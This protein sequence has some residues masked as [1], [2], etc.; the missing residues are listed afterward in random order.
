[1]KVRL[2]VA[3]FAALLPALP[4]SG[5][6]HATLPEGFA[7]VDEVVP[8][9]VVDLRYVTRK[10]FVGEPI[11]GYERPRCI[12]TRPAAEALAKVQ[13]DLKPFGLGL[14][15][16]DAYRP[17]QAVDHFA[18]WARKLDDKRMK[19]EYYPEVPKSELFKRGYI[20]AKSGHSR[21]STVDLT[22]VVL[23]S[24]DSKSKPR[25]IDMGSPFDFF[26]QKSWV[27]YAKLTG[28]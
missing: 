16:F 28:E 8:G 14:K 7:Y 18:R 2:I 1:M 17:Q 11:D 19:A 27:T 6:A 21:G 24:S 10:N 20:A 5:A 13:A 4:A 26:G 12:L 25:E 22:L 23:P 9:V 3:I 15:V